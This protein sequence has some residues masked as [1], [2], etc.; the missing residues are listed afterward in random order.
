MNY[1][2]LFRESF[3]KLL[4]PT[5]W[6]FG[7]LAALGGGF[8]TRA[9]FSATRPLTDLPPGL[10]DL[11]GD[12][13]Q[14]NAPAIIAAGILIS[15]VLL[16]FSTMGQAALLSL[17]NRL[18]NGERV[19]VG[20]GVD[21]AG[22]R[23]LHL[24]AVRF[25]LALPLIIIGAAAAGSLLAAFSG[26]FSQPESSTPSFDFSNLGALLGLAGLALIVS[27]LVSGIGIGAERA[28][29]IEQ[30]PIFKSLSLGASLFI[31]QIGDFII[32]GLLFIVVG[33]AVGLLFACVLIPIMFM[34]ATTSSLLSESQAVP[35]VTGVAAVW[36][37]LVGL[38]IGALA[39]I[40]N[41]SVWTLAYRQWRPQAV[42]MAPRDQDLI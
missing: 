15:L 36:T 25:L 23:F 5:L 10:S 27:L 39:A 9:N 11:L 22:K 37:L 20:L 2:G 35:Q 42:N 6:V 28:V 26:V 8:N 38:V 17:I 4:H 40:F 7:L 41:S 13:L 12:R 3:G 1:W 32:I 19:S 31:K 16:F 34:G 29:V 21:D 33:I 14:S 30:Q 24:L 18:E